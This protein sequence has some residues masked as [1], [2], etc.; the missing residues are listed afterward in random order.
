MNQL[1]SSI[2]Y[3]NNRNQIN[4]RQHINYNHRTR[5]N[6]NMNTIIYNNQNTYNNDIQR[7]DYSLSWRSNMNTNDN[8]NI[9]NI[10]NTDNSAYNL[11]EPLLNIPLSS[12]IPQNSNNLHE[13]T[14]DDNY[15]DDDY[16]ATTIYN[17]DEYN[18][19]MRINN[20]NSGPNETMYHSIFEYNNYNIRYN[21]QDLIAP[22]D[23]DAVLQHILNSIFE[24]EVMNQSMDNSNINHGNSI[25]TQQLI[26]K[27]VCEKKYSEIKNIIKNDICPISME[28]FLETDL[29]CL[30]SKCN[31]GIHHENKD[32]FIKLF[33][34]CPL[35]NKSLTEI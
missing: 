17:N 12:V 10:N 1:F 6:L 16:L 31:H 2:I 24:E 30:F 5:N 32:Q 3:N 8:I 22:S 28:S 20:L 11:N 13:I 29:I 35:C 26:Q 14:N 25:E 7:M 21:H 19:L 23:A 9:S 15:N 27:N 4:R 18:S 33:N 34:K